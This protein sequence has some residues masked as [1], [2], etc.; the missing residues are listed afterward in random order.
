MRGGIE[1]VPLGIDEAN[2]LVRRW[3]RHHRPTRGA[4]FALGCARRSGDEFELCGAAIVGRPVNRTMDDGWTLEVTRLV[5]D[6]TPN[7]CS[8]MYAAARRAAFAIGYRRIITYVLATEP[9]TSLRAAG[10]NQVARTRGGDTWNRR[11]RPRVDLHPL[12]PKLRFEAVK[13]GGDPGR[14]C[15]ESPPPT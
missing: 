7:A 5:S 4:K 12:V 14:Y 2:E 8:A 11:G 1:V 9:G 13:E 15:P 6:G 3:H 10:W